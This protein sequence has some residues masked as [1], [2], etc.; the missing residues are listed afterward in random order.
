MKEQISLFQLRLFQFLKA[1]FFTVIARF[2]AASTQHL[3][4]TRSRLLNPRLRTAS[5]FKKLETLFELAMTF[6]PRSCRTLQT[7]STKN[8]AILFIIRIRDSSYPF[9]FIFNPFCNPRF[10][11]RYHFLRSNLTKKGEILHSPNAFS[12]D[13]FQGIC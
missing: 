11:C 13:F 8:L 6:K 5:I 9:D 4:R 3:I 12:S 7:R 10:H 1:S 2:R